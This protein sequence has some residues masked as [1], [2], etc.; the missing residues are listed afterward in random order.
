LATNRL[1]S[2]DLLRGIAILGMALSGLIPDTLPA[3]MYHAQTPPPERSFKP[4]IAGLTWVDLVFPFFLFSMGAA[5]PFAMKKFVDQKSSTGTV[6]KSLISRWLLLA[7]FAILSQHLRLYS[8]AEAPTKMTALFSLI[9]LASI[10]LIYQKSLPKW[11]QT[12][13]FAIALAFLLLW[14]FPN[15][16]L[17]FINYRIDIILMVLGNVAF[18]GGL[19]WWFTREKPERRWIIAAVVAALFLA[20]SEP[21]IIKEL[22]NF[23]PIKLLKPPLGSDFDRVPVIYNMEF[24]KYLLIVIPGMMVGEQMRHL[25]EEITMSEDAQVR[26]KLTATEQP[27]NPPIWGIGEQGRTEGASPASRQFQ[28]RNP[29]LFPLSLALL[30]LNCY[31]LTERVWLAAAFVTL[32]ALVALYKTAEEGWKPILNVASIL[33][34]LGYILEPNAGGIHKDPSHLSY[35]FITSGLATLFLVGLHQTSGKLPKWIADCGANPILAYAL[36]ANFLPG[37]NTLTQYGAYA[38]EWFQNPWLLALLDGGLK[39]VLVASF[40]ALAS[41]WKLFL[42]A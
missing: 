3:W 36:I 39:T 37:L 10:L 1:Q 32:V 19:I 17:G 34:L 40:A 9:G 18:S 33:L 23:D 24:H 27:Q 30:T 42:K 14:K 21:G 15:N 16:Q 11:T 5:I 41:R 12:I 22:W 25:S 13:G 29:L 20:K 4:E 2:L 38:G 28:L 8:L 6:I 35:F 26:N 31:F 7:L